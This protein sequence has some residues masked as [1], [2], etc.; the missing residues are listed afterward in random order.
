MLGVS[1]QGP[2]G[3]LRAGQAWNIPFY[4]RCDTAITPQ[5][6]IQQITADSGLAVDYA[7]LEPLVRPAGYSDAEWIAWWSLVQ[8]EAG[9]T[10]GG[11]VSLLANL[12]TTMSQASLTGGDVGAFYSVPQLLTFAAQRQIQTSIAGT[13][14]FNDTAH[15]LSNTQVTAGNADGTQAGFTTSAADGGFVILNITND[16]VN[17]AVPGYWMP[18]PAQV[19]VPASGSV[20][21][22]TLV[23]RQGGSFTGVV[24]SLTNGASL[25]S[26]PV[27]VDSEGTNGQFSAYTGTNGAFALAGLPPDTYDVAVG[28]YPYT[29]LRINGL[30]INDGQ[31]VTTNVA[32]GPSTGVAIAGQVTANG[33]PVAGA[34]V[35][36]ADA[37]T[38][39]TTSATDTNGYF[40][41]AGAS[42][43]E[44]SLMVT[45]P[46]FVPY[47]TVT[48]LAD[49]AV[50]NVG[51]IALIP[52]AALAVNLTNGASNTI[53]GGLVTLLQNGKV[54][55]QQYVGA[56]GSV[57][58]IDLAAGTYELL[59]QAD[60]F[61]TISNTVLVGTGASIT[62]APVLTSLGRISGGVTDGNGQP[63]AG[64]E[65][66]VFGLDPLTESIAF[67]TPTDTNG[68][69]ALVGLPAGQ[70]EVT[71]GNNGGLDQQ[72]VA[73]DASLAPVTANLS[74]AA[75]VLQGQVF[76]AD[77]VTPVPFETVTLGQGNQMLATAQT[78]TNGLYVFRVLLP[79]AYD[80]WVGTG[81][82]LSSNLAVD[83]AANANPVVAPL[84]LGS[85]QFGG[86][87]TGQDGLGIA[88][89]VV[90]VR[91]PGSAAA[92]LSAATS[93][94]GGFT[95][96]GLAAGS[97]E[98]LIQ[99]AG[100]GPLWQSLSVL[101]STNQNFVLA[102]GVTVTGQI[103]DAATGL[104]VSNAAVALVDR[105]TRFVAGYGASDPNGNYAAH[106]VPPGSYDIII[107]E[108]SHQILELPNSTV[109][110]A[111]PILNASLLATNRLVQGT[112]A[113]LSSAPVANA[114][115]SILDPNTGQVLLQIQPDSAGRWAT[116]Q[117]GAGTY[118]IAASALGFLPPAPAT[119][120]PSPGQTTISP[121]ILTPVATDDGQGLFY[122][123]SEGLGA[124]LLSF[125]GINRPDCKVLPPPDPFVVCQ[126]CVGGPLGPTLLSHY[127]S[128]SLYAKVEN[129]IDF[130]GQEC[131]YWQATYDSRGV[132]VGANSGLAAVQAAQ[133]LGSTLQLIAPVAGIA[134][135]SPEDFTQLLQQEA[136]M[137]GLNMVKQTANLSKFVATWNDTYSKLQSAI[138]SGNSA[139]L[140]TGVANFINTSAGA[141][142]DLSGFLNN[143]GLLSLPA[144]QSFTQGTFGPWFR[145]L[146]DIYAFY[147][148]TKTALD[149]F[150]ASLSAYSQAQDNYVNAVNRYKADKLAYLAANH[151]PQPPPD[152]CDCAP[153]PYCCRHP[154]DCSCDPNPNCCQ[155]P[156]QCQPKPKQSVDPNDKLNTGFGPAGFVRADAT[157]TF[158]VDFENQPTAT[159]SAQQV[160]IVDMLDTNLDWSTLPVHRD[161][162]QQGECAHARRP[163]ELSH[164][165]WSGDR[166]ESG[167]GFSN[168]QSLKR[169]GEL[170]NPVH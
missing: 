137:T 50:A 114:A 88:D 122:V 56:S 49:G 66:N 168:L 87:V 79:G 46:G 147:Q 60:G 48:N 154:G 78:D 118:Q 124:A 31:V 139:T 62:N 13:L 170:A 144:Q 11:L 149:S 121:L 65:V 145:F 161:W 45:D 120:S 136:T 91:V 33:A 67:G 74:L 110:G 100:F 134:N 82:D 99:H 22:L 143:V 155:H 42:P 29:R 20:T 51:T 36:L 150:N 103:T 116:T 106:D 61:Q 32:L 47:V 52:G 39:V 89:A 53:S 30:T 76:Q 94:N 24:T 115:V 28:G 90:W 96:S 152:I 125:N 41:C 142:N 107:S 169:L 127:P 95:I 93:T 16:S 43:G 92:G 165:D 108:E 162:V 158:T 7:A 164:R 72:T 163:S 81:L 58:F 10:W 23:V 71:V 112:V 21:G 113:A 126:E 37:L 40:L 123:T 105:A 25:S 4:A 69:Y 141:I 34:L 83:V 159:A 109:T 17:L 148:A 167:A 101:A 70:Y 44:Y 128:A 140:T 135:P 153:N 130:A 102:A 19:I 9:P 75:S 3:V 104:A 160:T 64:I 138:Q 111:S 151:C 15:P 129:D 86:R 133:T 27:Q 73:I 157:I 26:V 98:I 8:R 2:A 166:S 80:L 68:H 84:I 59:A 119:V 85:L 12:A 6:D 5:F 35:E 57:N 55:A 117:L 1:F 14:Y 38:N 131:A 132:I 54:I 18:Q 63:I 146:R 77:G 156:E 97:Y